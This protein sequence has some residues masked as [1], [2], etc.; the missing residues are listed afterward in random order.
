[1]KIKGFQKQ[2][3]WDFSGPDAEIAIPNKALACK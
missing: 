1:M 2:T 3:K